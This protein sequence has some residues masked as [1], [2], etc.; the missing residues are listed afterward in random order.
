MRP[1]GRCVSKRRR[2]PAPV[3]GGAGERVDEGVVVVAGAHEEV[4]RH[5]DRRRRARRA[6]RPT[7]IITVASRIGRPRRCV[8]DDVEERVAR[9]R[10]SRWS[11][12]GEPELVE[13]VASARPSNVGA[14]QL[15]A[16][17]SRTPAPRVVGRERSDRARWPAPRRRAAP[18]RDRRPSGRRSRRAA[19][20]APR[21][22]P[23][24]ERTAPVPFGDH[25]PRC[26]RRR[27]SPT[28]PPSS[29]RPP[30]PCTTFAELDAA[31]NRLSPAAA[32]GRRAA[33]A[34]TWRSAW[35]TTPATSRSRGAAT[36]PGP[37][38]RRARRGCTSGE[39][40]YILDDCEAKVFITSQ[41]QGRPGGRDRRRTRRA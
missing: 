8:D 2:A 41:V 4:H 3:E 19:R 11:V 25:V 16:S 1:L 24:P 40:S 23:S 13:E 27:P 21:R 39:L 10:R 28:S 31:A 17:S 9:D 20:T 35:R 15:A 32:G 33:R 34:T 18:R 22:D 12:A 36:T 5:A 6:R 7:S 38:T 37:S 14:G 29:W 26:L 30:A